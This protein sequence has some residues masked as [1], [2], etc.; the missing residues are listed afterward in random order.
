MITLGTARIAI[1][2]AKHEAIKQLE[3]TTNKALDEMEKVGSEA[4]EKLKDIREKNPQCHE[5]PAEAVEASEE[6]INILDNILK[7]SVA[8]LNLICGYTCKEAKNIFDLGVKYIGSSTQMIEA[9]FDDLARMLQDF[10]K[11]L[12][13]ALTRFEEALKKDLYQSASYARRK[14]KDTKRFLRRKKDVKPPHHH[15]GEE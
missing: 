2:A 7:V 3:E 4:L 5:C 11:D 9:C 14:S 1:E 8:S 13:D 6:A 15:T 10:I 12:C